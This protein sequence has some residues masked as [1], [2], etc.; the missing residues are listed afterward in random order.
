VPVWWVRQQGRTTNRGQVVWF[1][2]ADEPFRCPSTHH[3]GVVQVEQYQPD[4]IQG[5]GHGV[6]DAVEIASHSSGD[7]IGGGPTPTRSSP[8]IHRVGARTVQGLRNSADRWI[9]KATPRMGARS[10]QP[11][12]ATE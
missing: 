8:T 10:P 7:S 11:V 12:D 3:T 6:P 4:A 5:A 1:G 9:G 2:G